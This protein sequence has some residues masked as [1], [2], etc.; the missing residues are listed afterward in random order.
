MMIY[1]LVILLAPVILFFI[2]KWVWRF[3]FGWKKIMA[4]VAIEIGWIVAFLFLA[5][6]GMGS[7]INSI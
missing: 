3:K 7:M 1:S 2:A 6:R 4:L 5:L